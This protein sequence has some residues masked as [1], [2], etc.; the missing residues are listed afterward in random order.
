MLRRGGSQRLTLLR[1]PSGSPPCRVVDA[2]VPVVAATAELEPVGWILRQLV[3]TAS[4]LSAAVGTPTPL[5]SPDQRVMPAHPLVD[6]VVFG[7]AATASFLRRVVLGLSVSGSALGVGLPSSNHSA[8][9]VSRMP[10]ADTSGVISALKRPRT[11]TG[12]PVV[13]TSWET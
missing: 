2:V 5:A 3:A 6:V 7:H 12:R 11:P 9:L 1:Q 8:R 4:P 10:V 13:G